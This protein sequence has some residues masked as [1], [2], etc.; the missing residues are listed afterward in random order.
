M[1]VRQTFEV[2]N[3]NKF[4]STRKRMSMVCRTPEG[5][6]FLYIKGADNVMV[7]RLR[8]DT[9]SVEQLTEALKGFAGEGLRTL[10]IAQRQLREQDWRAWDEVHRAAQQALSN[11][12]DALMEAA[13]MIEKDLQLL[14]ATAIEDKLQLGV[15]DTIAT[16]ALAGIRI[17][18]L[19]DLSLYVNHTRTHAFT[20]RQR[21]RETHTRTYMSIYGCIYV[22]THTGIRIWVLT[23]DKRETAENIGFA[24]NLLRDEMTRIYLLDGD[25]KEL[26]KLCRQKLQAHKLQSNPKVPR[27]DLA[28]LVDGKALLELTRCMDEDAEV[29]PAAKEAMMDFLALATNCKA[30]ICCRVSPDQKRQ[31]V[32]LVAKFVSPT[33]MTLSI[34]DGAND[35]PMILEASVRMDFS[36]NKNRVCMHTDPDTD[37]AQSE[38]QTHMSMPTPKR[39]HRQVGIGI[40]GNEGMQAVRSADYAIAQFRFL[41]RLILVHGRANYKRV[42]LVVSYLYSYVCACVCMHACMY[43]CVILTL[44]LSHTIQVVLYSLYKNCVLVSSMF[45]FGAYTGWTGT[46][47]YD[48]FMIA[49]YNVLF[50]AFG[51]LV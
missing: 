15:P 31:V 32:A 28:L 22:Y 2:L 33:P 13:E 3:I 49:G 9:P 17:L 4:N 50:A 40:S 26:H 37:K 44:T 38:R 11:R 46:A 7:D 16:L 25:I 5:K 43:T 20:H 14:G 39:A 45:C 36:A 6:I 18:L 48:S 19:T 12:E 27:E 35:V 34:G 23:G 41:K 30:V 29:S 47:L 42:S 51:I 8:A 1:G 21:E 24:C 10:V